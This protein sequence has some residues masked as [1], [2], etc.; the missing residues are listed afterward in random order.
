MKTKALLFLSVLLFIVSCDNND[1]IPDKIK[2][3]SWFVPG[4]YLN[5]TKACQFRF[6][7]SEFS[8]YFRDPSTSTVILDIT[9]SADDVNLVND[10]PGDYV[11]FTLEIPDGL[12]TLSI[13]VFQE[14]TQYNL[15]KIEAYS[16]DPDKSG[17]DFG[18]CELQ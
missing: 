18:W 7:E 16:S 11:G 10:V 12:S 3:P 14:K 4:T 9:Y 17:I 8:M 1:S 15:I 6:H 5:G 13:C 2:Y